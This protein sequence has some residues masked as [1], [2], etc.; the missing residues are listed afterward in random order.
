M[1]QNSC[2][3]ILRQLVALCFAL[4]LHQTAVPGQS[5]AVGSAAAVSLFDGKSLD[6]WE[7]DPQHWRVDSGVIVGEIP[8]GQSLN[9]NTW[10]VWRG[11][12]LA[13]FDLRLQFKLTGLPAA[14]S[15][16]QFRCQVENVIDPNAVIGRDFQAR[17]IVTTEG[18][19]IT[20]LIEKESDSSITVR[21]LTDSVTVSR[22]EIEETKTSPNSFM[23]E[24]LLKTLND[25]ERIELFK[26]LMAQ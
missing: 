3:V 26:Y 19:V 7:G 8:M 6:D 10:L 15:G 12:T 20:G 14:N 2:T 1:P 22:E 13:D 4:A 9:K 18:R 11:G 23:P 21:T 5:P 16:I 17:I 24:S 25:R